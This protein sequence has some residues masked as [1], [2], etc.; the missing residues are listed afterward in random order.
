M[1][2]KPKYYVSEVTGNKYPYNEYCNFGSGD[3]G[4]IKDLPKDE[5]PYG[6]EYE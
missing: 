3:R 5:Y 2:E 1:K 6:I 4:K